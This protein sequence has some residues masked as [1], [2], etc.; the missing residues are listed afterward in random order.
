MLYKKIVMQVK[1]HILNPW[2]LTE[3]VIKYIS[4]KTDLINVNKQK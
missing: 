3:D 4:V 2:P 1:C